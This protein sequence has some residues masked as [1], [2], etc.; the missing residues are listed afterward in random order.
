[1]TWHAREALPSPHRG[2]A[3]TLPATTKHDGH[4]RPHDHTL[5][6]RLVAVTSTST[7]GLATAAIAAPD[8]LEHFADA[9]SDQIVAELKNTYDIN[10]HLMQVYR[11]G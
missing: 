9:A 1:L 5:G 3:G 7:D 4:H 8:H 11:V 10:G 2:F 6:S